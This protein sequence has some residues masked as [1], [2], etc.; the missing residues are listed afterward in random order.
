MGTLGGFAAG[1]VTGWLRDPSG[2]YATPFPV[3]RHLSASASR[4]PQRF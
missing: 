2:G 1:Y 3:W 4:S